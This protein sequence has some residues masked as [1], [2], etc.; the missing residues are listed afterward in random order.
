MDDKAVSVASSASG[1]SNLSWNTSLS[2]TSV[3]S[4]SC[5]TLSGN[6][7]HSAHGLDDV[8]RVVRTLNLQRYRY[9]D[10][11]REEVLGEGETYVV[12]RC[13]ARNE[14]IFA[15]K[16][17]KVSSDAMF[18]KRLRSVILELQIMRHP[19]F[20]AHPNIM[21][22][23]G[24]G[25]NTKGNIIMPYVV[26][27]YASLGTLRDYITG[28]KPSLYDIE[29]LLGDVASGLAAL[30]TGGIVHG[31]MKLDNV[32]VFPSMDRPAKALAK[33]A[34]F[35]HALILNDASKSP[36]PGNLIYSGTLM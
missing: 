28:S 30:H 16:H 10:L 29:T 1:A 14:N 2:R 17:L 8:I 9:E 33:I 3:S 31:D 6:R 18:H 26:V 12:E 23:L 19:P 21:P 7:S 27:E 13:V 25:W 24:Y 5:A 32:L 15:V 34:D 4:L 35:G 20:K 11:S 22:G 36:D